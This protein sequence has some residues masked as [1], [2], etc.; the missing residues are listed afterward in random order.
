MPIIMKSESFEIMRVPSERFHYQRERD[1]ISLPSSVPALPV[2]CVCWCCLRSDLWVTEKIE[3][4]NYVRSQF[5]LWLK[6][7]PLKTSRFMPK[8]SNSHVTP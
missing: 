5:P 2:L 6:K 7:L 1:M 4:K 8:T 3:C